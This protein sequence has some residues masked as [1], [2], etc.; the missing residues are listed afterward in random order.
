MCRK[1]L[2]SVSTGA[3][4]Y[5]AEGTQALMKLSLTQHSNNAYKVR[6]CDIWVLSAVHRD[7]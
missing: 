1:V 6:T 2:L 7:A 5:Q 3:C 4:K